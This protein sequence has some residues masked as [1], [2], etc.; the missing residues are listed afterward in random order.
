[1]NCKFKAGVRASAFRNFLN[2]FLTPHQYHFIFMSDV[3]YDGFVD[4]FQSVDVVLC[5]L[6]YIGR[7][8]FRIAGY[9]HLQA[10]LHNI[11]FDVLSH[12]HGVSVE[13]HHAGL[14]TVNAQGLAAERLD[15]AVL[16]DG[17]VEQLE[18]Q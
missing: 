4:L 2:L 18:R 10:S 14:G 13:M 17:L 5:T 16:V 1:M 15:A 3:F 7:V 8:F 9:N 12:H 6:Q 11:H